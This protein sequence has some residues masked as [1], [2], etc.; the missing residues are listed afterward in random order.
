MIYRD[1]V[2]ESADRKYL[3]VVGL[4]FSLTGE[5]IYMTVLSVF[6]TI[7]IMAWDVLNWKL[8]AEKEFSIGRV[9]RGGRAL[10]VRGGVLIA[11]LR[12]LELWNFELSRCIR[13]WSLDVKSM[14]SISDDQVL[15]TT[16]EEEEI[17]VDTVT[18]LVSPFAVSSYKVIACYRNL[19]LLANTDSGQTGC[20]KLQQLGQ[21]VPRLE[22]SLTH[23]HSRGAL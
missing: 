23:S 3:T 14:F 15:C 13:R 5:T 12:T 1:E 7:R 19:H 22:L 21:S 2:T 10:A 16:N 8:K 4:A 11:T 18:G 17:I 20:T 9:V 6:C